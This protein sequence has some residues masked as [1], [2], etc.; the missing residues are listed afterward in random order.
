MVGGKLKEVWQFKD[1]SPDRSGSKCPPLIL[2]GRDREGMHGVPVT[3]AAVPAAPAP[4]HTY[5]VLPEREGLF[6]IIIQ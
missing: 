5:E 3:I 6:D 2:W 4:S 1:F